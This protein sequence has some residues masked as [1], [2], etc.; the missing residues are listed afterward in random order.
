M[1]ERQITFKP[2]LNNVVLRQK[3]SLI[4]ACIVR[5]VKQKAKHHM[6]MCLNLSLEVCAC[7]H[8]HE[9]QLSHEALVFLFLSVFILCT[10]FCRPSQNTIR[11]IP[12]ISRAI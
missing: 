10:C 11:N 12:R 7:L 4:G 1:T 8:G 5:K 6:A 2:E 9:K 3:K